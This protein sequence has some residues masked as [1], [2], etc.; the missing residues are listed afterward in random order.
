LTEI[1]NKNTTNECVPQYPEWLSCYCIELPDNLKPLKLWEEIVDKLIAS[2]CLR[3]V[4]PSLV[5]DYALLRSRYYDLEQKLSELMENCHQNNDYLNDI[6][7]TS[8]NSLKYLKYAQATE[9]MIWAMAFNNEDG[10]Y[11]EWTWG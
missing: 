2:G 6:Y 8:A 7:A 5:E 11:G 10:L 1:S 4:H 9:D 3:F